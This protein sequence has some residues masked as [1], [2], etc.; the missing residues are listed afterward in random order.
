MYSNLNCKDHKTFKMDYGKEL[1]DK[2]QE[3]KT[4]TSEG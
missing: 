1:E 4:Q 3:Y 2:D